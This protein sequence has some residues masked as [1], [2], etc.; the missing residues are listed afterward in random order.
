MAS[1]HLTDQATLEMHLA[2]LIDENEYHSSDNDQTKQKLFEYESSDE[3]NK[4]ERLNAEVKWEQL[5]AAM[6]AA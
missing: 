2:V 1:L 4:F 5:L 6:D 3:K